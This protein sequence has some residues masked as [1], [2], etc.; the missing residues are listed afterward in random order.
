MLLVSWEVEMPNKKTPAKKTETKLNKNGTPR[1][2]RS[3][4]IPLNVLSAALKASVV[5]KSQQIEIDGYAP[6]VRT[7][8]L[9][10][11]TEYLNNNLDFKPTEASIRSRVKKVNELLE[12]NGLDYKFKFQRRGNKRTTKKLSAEDVKAMFV[13]GF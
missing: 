4:S 13:S 2:P 7:I 10:K 5:A 12:T 6:E 11:V 1:K 9:A 8:D 3:P